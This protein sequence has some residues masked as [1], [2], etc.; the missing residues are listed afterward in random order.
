MHSFPVAIRSSVAQ[1]KHSFWWSSER[2]PLPQNRQ[3]ML[4]ARCEAPIL[5]H[6]VH[7]LTAI[8]SWRIRSGQRAPFRNIG[9]LI[10]SRARSPKGSSKA[11]VILAKRF[12]C[13]SGSHRG[14]RVTLR[15]WNRG[16]RCNCSV[17]VSIGVWISIPSSSISSMQGTEATTT[18]DHVKFLVRVAEGIP[19]LRRSRIAIWCAWIAASV[20]SEEN[21][22][23]IA[24]PSPFRVHL[25]VRTSKRHRSFGRQ[26]TRTNMFLSDIRSA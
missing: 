1:S 18:R 19:W 13:R 15:R 7:C 22:R 2:W 6:R 16:M 21:F 8:L 10:R 3:Q 5:Q 23:L 14:A 12:P 11:N 20:V 9:R 26:L 24:W 4:H 25:A 17:T